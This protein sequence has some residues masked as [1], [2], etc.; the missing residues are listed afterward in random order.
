MVCLADRRPCFLAEA[1]W[2]TIPFSKECPPKTMSDLL[3][4]IL[5]EIPGLLAATEGLRTG[6]PS[7]YA[8]IQKA[9]ELAYWVRCLISALERWKENNIWTHP[10]ICTTPRLRNLD[11]LALCKLGTGL[12]PQDAQLREALNCYLAAHLILARIAGRFGERSFA[13]K[14]SLR[15]PYSLCELITA[16][17]HISEEHISD[18]GTGLISLRVTAFPLKVAQSTDEVQDSSLFEKVRALL[19]QINDHF[20]RRY[21][22][23]YSV[24]SASKAYDM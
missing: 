13:I 5:V 16:I 20:T 12:D 9:L 11:I 1:A 17:I 14:A 23:N 3:I 21:N 24:P 19:D 8:L 2:K 15:P 10:A 4:D 22:I 7:Q 6:G 18:S